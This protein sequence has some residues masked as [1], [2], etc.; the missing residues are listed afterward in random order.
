MTDQEKVNHLTFTS[1]E[2]EEKTFDGTDWLLADNV[3]R[4]QFCDMLNA[5]FNSSWKKRMYLSTN[6]CIIKKKKTCNINIKQKHAT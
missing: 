4:P 5:S 6:A 2:S 1:S 3:L